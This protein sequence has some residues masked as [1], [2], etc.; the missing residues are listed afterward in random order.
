M[1]TVSG[2]VAEVGDIKRFDNPE[3]TRNW[4]DMP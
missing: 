4:Q 2:F 3:T 1:K